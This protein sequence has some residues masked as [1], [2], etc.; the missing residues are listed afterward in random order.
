MKIV[1]YSIK[2]LKPVERMKFQRE[3]YGFKDIS[4]NSKYVYH[5]QGLMT[6]IKHKKI[7]YTGIIV[8]E[9][10]LDKLVRLLK[11]HKVKMHVAEVSK[12]SKH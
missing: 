12:S 2:H 4:N 6:N 8:N 11:K 9:K 1:C 10:N 5:R 3:M 7:Y